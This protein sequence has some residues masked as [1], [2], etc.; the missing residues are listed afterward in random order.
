MTKDFLIESIARSVILPLYLPW[1]VLDWVDSDSTKG[2][3]SLVTAQVSSSCETGLF[4]E[5][6]AGANFLYQ[7]TIRPITTS[8]IITPAA[9]ITGVLLGLTI[10]FLTSLTIDL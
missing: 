2:F 1:I 7:N 9:I 4:V 6:V 3:P 10:K 8:P 5:R